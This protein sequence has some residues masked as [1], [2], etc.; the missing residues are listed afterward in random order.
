MDTK[1]AISVVMFL[2]VQDISSLMHA[3]VKRFS[4]RPTDRKMYQVQGLL[5][6]GVAVSLLLDS[7]LLQPS[8]APHLRPGLPFNCIINVDLIPS[9]HK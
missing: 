2:D 1:C 5:R 8:F 9:L 6:L 7:P 4:V 3:Y